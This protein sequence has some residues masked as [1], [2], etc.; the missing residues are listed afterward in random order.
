[1]LFEWFT[2]KK[3]EKRFLSFSPERKESKKEN[4]KRRVTLYKSSEDEDYRY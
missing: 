1:M 4:K 3:K 2:E